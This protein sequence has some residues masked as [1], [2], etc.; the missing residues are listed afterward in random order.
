MI[1]V[2]KYYK[3]INYKNLIVQCTGNGIDSGTFTGRV[4][5]SGNSPFLENGLSSLWVN[6]YFEP[7]EPIET[8]QPEQS[9]TKDVELRLECLKLA[10]IGKGDV[11]SDMVIED[12]QHYYDWITKNHNQ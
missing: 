2:G 10:V 5:N 4:V 11:L 6:E 3:G 1:E 9:P 12:A 8:T 7:F